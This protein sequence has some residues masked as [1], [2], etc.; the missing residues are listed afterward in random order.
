MLNNP[1][2]DT[3]I[4]V[5]FKLEGEAESPMA[6]SKRSESSTALSNQIDGKVAS[7]DDAG[8]LITDIPNDA[9]AGLVGDENVSINFGPHE[10][11]GIHPPDHQPDATLVASL[12]SEGFVMIEIVG[13]SLGDMLGIKPGVDVKV[14]W[15]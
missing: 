13:V 3:D 2:P 10:T 11:L 7:C 14:A 15:A 4:G 9:V 6:N 12:G 8:N 5:E 1:V